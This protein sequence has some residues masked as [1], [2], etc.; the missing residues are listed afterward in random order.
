MLSLV[1]PN[2]TVSDPAPITS[3]SLSPDGKRAAA[4][5]GNG[6]G[7]DICVGGAG[8]DLLIGGL[9]G[10]FLEPAARDTFRY[11]AVSDSGL[12]A[13]TWDTIRLFDKGTLATDDRIDLSAIDANPLLAGNQAFVFRGA[14]AFTATR[15][16]A[17]LVV[18]GADTLVY[19]DNDTDAAAEMILKVE[20][21]TGLTAAD[22]IL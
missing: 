14:G 18:S 16:E 7:S 19:V 21:V 3:L 4:T 17:R 1:L 15:G 9:E 10:L 13:M 11:N 12:T 8:A 20:G 5:I 2:Y 6:A 22:F